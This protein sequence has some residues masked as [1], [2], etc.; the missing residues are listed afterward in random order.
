MAWSHL[1][2]VIRLSAKLCYK[3]VNATMTIAAVRAGINVYQESSILGKYFEPLNVAAVP[4]PDDRLA[5]PD[6]PSGHVL[7]QQRRTQR[8]LRLAIVALNEILSNCV[9]EPLPLF[10]AAPEAYP[11]PSIDG[12]F[13]QLLSNAIPSRLDVQSSRL[14]ATGRAG[15]LQ[16]LQLAFQYL[17][18]TGATHVLIGGV[19][20]LI[21]LAA[22]GTWDSEDRISSVNTTDGL[23]QEKVLHFFL[24]TAP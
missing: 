17:N 19:D 1:R 21:D 24:T 16:A 5:L 4:I 10:L 6:I 11:Y 9:R 8:M 2:E 12:H 15:G 18:Q 3:E 22:M 7:Y 13:L 23:L 20:S 14:I